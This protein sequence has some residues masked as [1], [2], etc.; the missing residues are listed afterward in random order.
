MHVTYG[1]NI[2]FKFYF[3]VC[4]FCVHDRYIIVYEICLASLSIFLNL[5]KYNW[6]WLLLAS[7]TVFRNFRQFPEILKCKE[8]I[9]FH[10][11]WVFRGQVA[12]EGKF[13]EISGNLSMSYFKVCFSRLNDFLKLHFIASYTAKCFKV[14]LK[15][16]KLR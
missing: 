8:K 13:V 10:K 6:D 5:R 9:T 4:L 11:W 16:P 15:R 14:T 2:D 3:S 12:F 1:K 7:F